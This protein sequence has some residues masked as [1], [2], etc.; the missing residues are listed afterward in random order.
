M[1][2]FFA[3]N[4][5]AIAELLVGSRGD[6]ALDLTRKCIRV[7]SGAKRRCPVDTGRLRSS[8]RWT[9]GRD[10]KGLFGRV[11]TE[12]EYAYFVHEGH[13][14]YEVGSTRGPGT[15][16]R[17]ESGGDVVY[18]SF[19]NTVSIPAMEGRP[20]LKDALRDIAGL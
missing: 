8:I 11:G 1:P 20:F 3:P 17:F 4:P 19:P 2:A 6:V 9:L 16:L 12:V 18:V 15:A 14:P 10:G 13:G 5:R 7:Q